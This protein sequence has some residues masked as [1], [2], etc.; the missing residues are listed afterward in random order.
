MEKFSNAIAGRA[1]MAFSN[2]AFS[3]DI[4]NITS[5]DPV[6][7]LVIVQIHPATDEEPALQTGWI[8]YSA[9]WVGNGWGMYAAP[10]L[11]TLCIVVYQQG[12]RQIPIAATPLF[13][14]SVRPL[15]VESGEFWIVHQSGSSLKFTNDGQ[16]S[17]SSNVQIDLTAPT[18][19]INAS[20]VLNINT[21]SMKIDASTE[22]DIFSQL[23]KV[24]SSSG[25]FETLLK[26]D[27]TPTTNLQGS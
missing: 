17:I 9:A 13:G 18:V 6:N 2:T 19:N 5:Y 22:C 11:N 23:I 14:G 24:G 8:P 7:H 27:N 1:L 25:Y 3:A 12:S 10:V 16:V 20:D 26:S 15:K 21:A 4:G